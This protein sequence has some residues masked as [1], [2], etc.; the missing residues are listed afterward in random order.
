METSYRGGQGKDRQLT[1]REAKHLQAGG[2]A[3]VESPSTCIY[4]SHMR[5]G[6]SRGRITNEKPELASGCAPRRPGWI[7]SKVC[8]WKFFAVG[9]WLF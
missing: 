9:G 7:P 3:L 1:E 2:V 6:R 5:W 4:M 8:V